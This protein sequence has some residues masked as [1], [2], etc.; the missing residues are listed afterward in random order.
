MIGTGPL[1]G[2]PALNSV[3][4]FGWGVGCGDWG[5]LDEGLGSGLGVGFGVE[6]G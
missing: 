1:V 3:P 6:L 5:A 4:L 2:P